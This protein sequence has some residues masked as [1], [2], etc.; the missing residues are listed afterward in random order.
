MQN[1]GKLLEENP[2]PQRSYD[3]KSVSLKDIAQEVDFQI[4]KLNEDLPTYEYMARIESNLKVINYDTK[5][6]LE[7]SEKLKIHHIVVIT[8]EEIAFL[9]ST[10]GLNLAEIESEF[11]IYDGGFWRRVPAADFKSFLGRCA[12]KLG[13]SEFVARYHDFHDQL[14][15]QATATLHRSKSEKKISVTKL[16]LLNGTLSVSP[17]GVNLGPH[18][19]AD[20]FTYKLKFAYDP[21]YTCPKWTNFLNEVLPDIELQN[22]L[23]ECLAYVF[24]PNSVLKLEKVLMCVGSGANGKSVV[25]EVIRALYGSENVSEYTLEQLTEANGYC[26]YEL[27]VKLLNYSPEISGKIGSSGTFKALASGEPTTA[28]EIY[29]KPITIT[30]Y[31]RLAFNLNELPRDVEQ[32]DGFYRRFLIIP[33]NVSIPPEKQDKKLPQR[34][35]CDELPGVLNWI[36]KGLNRLLRQGGFTESKIIKEQ[37][38]EYRLES[39]SVLA[40]LKELNYEKDAVN[41]I[42]LQTLY[43][44]YSAYCQTNNIPPT[45]NKQFS[46]RLKNKGFFI[47]RIGSGMT[48][49]IGRGSDD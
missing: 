12:E 1:T 36:L 21:K 10:L 19:P 17:D 31:A 18:N 4:N 15:K 29:K 7:K 5:A 3:A 27:S 49:H 20:L 28:R 34:I 8:L 46:K 6:G 42:L 2:I 24:V 35:I 16:N 38:D 33:F 41:K 44:E 30:D 14:L 40:F 13:I 45:G 48:V 22:I 25:Y 32:T 47:E 23:S 43:R 37:V 11:Y 9:A 26:R 39:D